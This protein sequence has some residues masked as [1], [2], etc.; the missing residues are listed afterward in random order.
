MD[1]LQTLLRALKQL[2]WQYTSRIFKSAYCNLTI[3]TAIITVEEFY[4]IFYKKINSII[5]RSQPFSM[6]K[7]LH[8][9]L[10]VL[11]QF[12]FNLLALT[13][14]SQS[15]IP[16]ASAKPS[17][18]P[19]FGNV[20]V[21]SNSAY[22][23]FTLFGTN[24]NSNVTVGPL[25]GYSF[26]VTPDGNYFSSV[27]VS[28]S[29]GRISQPI[30]VKFSPGAAQA[31]NSNIPVTGG[32][33]M[34]F[35]VTTSGTGIV[36]PVSYTTMSIHLLTGEVGNQTSVDA[37]KVIFDDKFSATIG[38][39]DS[40]KF[41]NQD[42]N[43]AINRDGTFLSLEG[44]PAITAKDT[45]PLQTWK[46]KQQQ[47]YLQFSASNF[48]P[49]LSASLRDQYLNTETPISLS[50]TTIIPF[51]NDNASFSP[52]RF[53]IIL[54]TAGLLPVTLTDVTAYQQDK[55]I[56]VDWKAQGETNINNYQI[57]K[58]INGEQFSK[59]GT[60]QP[61]GNNGVTQTYSWFDGAAT[62]GNNFYRIKVTEK[63]GVVKYSPVVKVAIN[64]GNG[65]IAIYP[66]PVH[67]SVI[68]L[69]M[70]NL[71]KGNY[72]ISLYNNAGQK[73]YAGLIEH[74]G[75]SATYSIST[76]RQLSKG[77]CSLHV[78]KGEITVNKMV[79]IQ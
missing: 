33:A 28:P 23:S 52:D 19:D 22:K 59:V 63:S 61:S 21:D 42:E 38:N 60:I 65:S 43:I 30:Y 12:I 17:F 49:L 10:I 25:G 35:N 79:V 48:S 32:G 11:L 77:I 31:Y 36:A 50:S 78:T 44:R 9:S 76:G 69:Q 6:K 13:G 16:Y 51:T 5:K 41:T 54:K 45:L 8:L 66:N 75:G 72:T 73:L 58:S 37:A 29:N 26:S 24:L 1:A 67:G 39:E 70:N 68:G 56:L 20:Y 62:A 27:S 57:E 64:K 47:Y 2:Y 40:Y 15:Q 7:F 3:S 4:S 71:E 53:S 18:I 14:W 34:S 74:K 55:G 46:L